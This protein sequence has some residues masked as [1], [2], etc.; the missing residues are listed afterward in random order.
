MLDRVN[1]KRMRQR[2]YRSRLKRG[3]TCVLIELDA[4]RL[5]KLAKLDY[6]RGDGGREYA[7]AI[8]RMID[9]IEL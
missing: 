2:R 3:I 5:E 8:E 9:M 6:L 4:A 7:K 1:G